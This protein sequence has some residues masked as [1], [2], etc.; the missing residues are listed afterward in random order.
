MLALA[1]RPLP[2]GSSPLLTLM[3]VRA[4]HRRPEGLSAL[5][6]RWWQDDARLDAEEVRQVHAFMQDA[7]E[8]L[9][10]GF[11]YGE[12][13]LEGIGP[14]ARRRALAAG[15]LERTDYAGFY[16]ERPPLPPPDVQPYLMGI[17]REE[18][19]G[20]EGSQISHFFFPPL[21]LLDLRPGQ[22]EVLWRALRGDS[23]QQIADALRVTLS[24]VK[25]RWGAIRQRFDEVLPGL[26]PEDEGQLD[27]LPEPGK[28]SRRERG[29]EKRGRVLEYL[30]DHPEELRPT[31][32]LP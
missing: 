17:T 9:T 31:V 13:L 21:A 2:D 29:P 24:A 3:Q 20:K 26:L 30:R 28:T 10:R 19:F 8:R 25:K 7:F 4:A 6:T 32:P 11:R 27:T 18:A 14:E 12:L 1:T 15:F 5:I 22:Q 23:D 16:R